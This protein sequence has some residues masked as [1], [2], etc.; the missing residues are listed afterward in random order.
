MLPR[1]QPEFHESDYGTVIVLE[2]RDG[3]NKR[4]DISC[5][6]SLCILFMRPDGSNFSVDGC[7]FPSMDSAI[8][9]GADGKFFYVIQPEILVPAGQWFL[10]GWVDL[11]MGAW[12]TSVVPFTVFPN[13]IS[14]A[15]NLTP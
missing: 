13:L 6:Q 12:Y 1:A 3:R 5:A 7:W 9:D 4:V 11:G 15:E 8:L 2:I 14:F 10:Q